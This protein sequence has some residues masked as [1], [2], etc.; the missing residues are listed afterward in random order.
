MVLQDLP[1]VGMR[2]ESG[3]ND[4]NHI[5][6]HEVLFMNIAISM[7]MQTI[8]MFFCVLFFNA[9]TLSAEP[10]G[11][12]IKI[13]KEGET[14]IPLVLKP[15]DFQKEK[16]G[17]YARE[18]DEVIKSGLDFTGMFSILK[19]PLNV[20]SGGDLYVAGERQV[21]FASLSSVGA[22]LYAGG[23]MER[24]GNTINM[25]MEVYDVLTGKLMLKKLYT[26]RRDELRS[27]GHRFCADLMELITGKRSIFDSKLAFVSSQGGKK[28][29]FLAEFDGYG[30]TQ[31]T[32]TG[33]LALTPSL[34][35]DSELLAYLTYSRGLP[36]LQIK[37]LATRKIV[38]VTKKGVKIDPAWRNG[39]L[40]CATTFS[41]EGD[42]EI[43]L[44]GSDGSVGRRLTRSRGIDVSPSFSPDGRKMAFV[45][46]RHGS[47]QIFI[48]DLSTGR[49]TRLT[50]SGKY[51]TQPS[52]SPV[53]NKIVYSS[54]QNNGEINIFTINADGSGLRQLTYRTRQN[55]APSWSPD[56]SM[57]VF[58]STRDGSKKL[59]MMN[60]NGRNQRSLKIPGEQMQPSWSSLR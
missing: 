50:F 42:Q 7:R 9:F 22:E 16:Y 47:P 24:R 59:F 45:S 40:E 35:P 38:S 23:V 43:Y 54:M 11:Q 29:I 4:G 6:N 10:V 2:R 48:K 21:N 33:G 52:W 31:V 49:E 37:N 39:S 51:N 28:E 19:A 15:L 46:S 25:A 27:M 34:S 30:A 36:D 20:F 3:H 44:V 55:E 56:G 57:I 18:L 5:I 1:T 26:G 12:Y 17:E 14:T 60:A 8:V 13:A 32:D 53:D 41:F 58:S